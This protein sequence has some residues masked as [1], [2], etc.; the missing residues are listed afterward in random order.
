MN[1]LSD[2]DCIF[3][4][5]SDRKEDAPVSQLDWWQTKTFALGC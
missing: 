5:S 2:L 1:E 3:L 4:E